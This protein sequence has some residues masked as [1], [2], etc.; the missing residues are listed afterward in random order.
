MTAAELRFEV[1]ESAND[2]HAWACPSAKEARLGTA[3]RNDILLSKS[4][5]KAIED[6]VKT[7][8][9]RKKKELFVFLSK[10]LAPVPS[11][12]AK[13]PRGLKAAARPAL[14][15]LPPDLSFASKERVGLLI[16]KRHAAHR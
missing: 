9:P 8:P 16:A 7:V 11:L 14:E 1:A 2:K 6:A 12:R 3:S 10:E 13:R 15:G 4:T 5:L